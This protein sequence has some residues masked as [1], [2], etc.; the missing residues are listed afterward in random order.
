MSKLSILYYIGRNRNSPQD[1]RKVK[2]CTCFVKEQQLLALMPSN[3]T[4]KG[5]AGC[6]GKRF[7]LNLQNL[8]SLM[9]SN[10]TQLKLFQLFGH[11]FGYLSILKNQNIDFKNS[12]PQ[13]V[14]AKIA[15]SDRSVFFFLRY[16]YCRKTTKVW[17]LVNILGR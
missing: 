7:K 9:S 15:F 11:F 2:S 4:S 10:G 8:F 14:W 3:S 6:R 1:M 13:L 5:L 16:I 12:P 17:M